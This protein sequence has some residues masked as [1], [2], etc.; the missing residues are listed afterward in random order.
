L[1]IN[2]GST[3]GSLD[4]LKQYAEIDSRIKI[5]DRENKGLVYSLN[6]GLSLAKGNILPEWMLMIFQK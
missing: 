6:E 1:I 5:I 2:D 3:D 4:V